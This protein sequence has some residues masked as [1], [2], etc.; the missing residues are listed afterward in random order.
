[1]ATAMATKR[2]D[3]VAH[4]ETQSDSELLKLVLFQMRHGWM[5]RLVILAGRVTMVFS[6]PQSG[7][8]DFICQVVAA[9]I[10]S[11]P[12]KTP[13]VILRNFV[14][15]GPQL[16]AR[17]HEFGK[18]LAKLCQ[19]G[20][21]RFGTVRMVGTMSPVEIDRECELNGASQ[22]MAMIGST[23]QLEK[24]RTFMLTA[25]NPDKHGE[26]VIIV[27]E[28]DQQ[29]DEICGEEDVVSRRPLTTKSEHLLRDIMD[30][31]SSTVMISATPVML[32]AAARVNQVVCLDTGMD[33]SGRIY[34]SYKDHTYVPVDLDALIHRNSPRHAEAL[35]NFDQVM[36]G[37]NMRCR[38]D[39]GRVPG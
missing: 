12:R 25:Y 17:A 23:A 13:I 10:N 19:H 35:V 3:Q 16:Q 30:A 15:D 18:K 11:W 8:T 5:L 9:C 36:N 20:K 38:R 1:M 34:H 22:V 4:P 37:T 14:E 32:T 21:F 27:D 24:L 31:A 33:A 26:I 28:A 39:L 6:P 29:I 2:K 7:K